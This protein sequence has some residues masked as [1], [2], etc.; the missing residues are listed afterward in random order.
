MKNPAARTKLQFLIENY[1]LEKIPTLKEYLLL[2]GI[3]IFEKGLRH[4]T[5]EVYNNISEILIKES[6][7]ELLDKFYKQ[8]KQENLTRLKERELAIQIATGHVIKA[9]SLYANRI[10]ASYEKPRHLLAGHWTVISNAGLGYIDKVCTS[11][12]LCPSYSVANQL[13]TNLGI[14]QGISRVRKLT[15]DV[16]AYCKEIGV[17]LNLETGEGL[18][19]KRVVLGIDGGRTRTRIYNGE[20]NK[21]GNLKFETKWREPKLFV[22]YVIGE[23]GQLE[24]KQR[25][26]YG[27]RFDENDMLGL[28]AEYLKALEIIKCGQVQILADGAPWIWNNIKPILL[29]LGVDEDRTVETLDYYHAIGYV[30]SLIEGL[31]LKYNEKK[32]AGLLKQSKLWLWGGQSNKIVPK[33]NQFY[34]RPNKLAKRW[35]NYLDKHENKMQYADYQSNNLMCG[36]GIIESGIRRIIN[37]KFKPPGVFWG[38]NNVGNLFFFA[39]LFCLIDGIS[40]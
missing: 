10:P 17:G 27:C 15:N 1:L 2:G 34:R 36:S 22:I 11:S 13:L 21:K 14:N 30:N 16:G 24:N 6:S 18:K 9:Y 31:P 33:C 32:R 38:E 35:V 7:K 12:V 39:P 23:N 3:L 5:D 37:L 25:P 40:F 29:K 28:L 8:A 4:C 26:V 20:R 19:G